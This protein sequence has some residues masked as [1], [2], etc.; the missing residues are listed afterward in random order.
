MAFP[1][2]RV[3][4]D[5]GLKSWARALL[6]STAGVVDVGH[7]RLGKLPDAELLRVVSELLRHGIVTDFYATDPMRAGL[8]AV[9]ATRR[10][11]D[12]V[13]LGGKLGACGVQVALSLASS[14]RS[15]GLCSWIVV[16]H[17]LRHETN[18]V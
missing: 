5:T 15:H 11:K 16:S 6:R 10:H 17:G 9:S 18:L 8:V 7:A 3:D 2:W 14:A 12:M 1:F 13:V 4:V